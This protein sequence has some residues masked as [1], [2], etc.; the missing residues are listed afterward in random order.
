MV[1]CKNYSL[2]ATGRRDLFE[3]TDTN[4]MYVLLKTNLARVLHATCIHLMSKRCWTCELIFKRRNAYLADMIC[5]MVESTTISSMKCHILQFYFLQFKR[6]FLNFLKK[7][8]IKSASNKWVAKLTNTMGVC[9]NC[10]IKGWIQSVGKKENWEEKKMDLGV[11]V[12]LG[13]RIWGD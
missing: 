10:E 4:L 9:A 8:T 6:F 1:S 3:E 2:H 12:L 7:E 5:G 13:I 11:R